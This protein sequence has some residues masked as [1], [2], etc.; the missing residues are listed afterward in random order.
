M[1]NKTSLHLSSGDKRRELDFYPTPDEVTVALIEFLGIKNISIIEPAC[2]NGAMS[3]VLE[4]NGNKVFSSDLRDS[5][6]GIGGLDFLSDDFKFQ[7]GEYNAV[8]TNPPF[9]VAEKFILKALELSPIV[10]MVLKSQYWH[11][12][13]RFG[14]FKDNTPAY[15]LPL[16]W[17]PDFMGDGGSP[18]MEVAWSVWIAGNTSAIY[19]PLLKPN[20]QLLLL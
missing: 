3:K 15:I 14:L 13:S 1:K 11:A 5:G 9:N 2:G 17:R 7:Y 16:T 18:I 8:I 20:S 10:A 4:K 12:K 6:Y 19:Q